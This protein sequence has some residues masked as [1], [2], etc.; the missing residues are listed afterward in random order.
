MKDLLAIKDACRADELSIDVCR[1][2]VTVS[3]VRLW[4]GV[5]VS[6]AFSEVELRDYEV[7]GVDFV[8]LVC[9]SINRAF[10]GN[11]DEAGCSDAPLRQGKEGD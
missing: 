3:A 1:G 11:V 5:V 7:R 9:E 2:I 6:R 10:D 8:D 4:T